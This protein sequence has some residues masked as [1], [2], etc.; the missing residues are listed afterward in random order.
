MTFLAIE[1]REARPAQQTAG[2][3]HLTRGELEMALATVNGI[4]IYYEVHGRGEPVLLIMGLGANATAWV[5]QIPELSVEYR[6]IAFDNRGSGRSG[7]PD[8]AY[9]IAQM[10]DDAALLLDE[11]SIH[12][13]HVFG[14]SMGGM[15]A[16][17]LALRHPER[18]RTLILGGTMPGGPMSVMAGPRLIQQWIAAAP[19]PLPQAIEAGLTFLYSDEFVASNRE[20]LIQRSLENAHLLPPGHALQKQIM[21]VIAFNAYGRL[22][23]IHVPTL[24]LTGTHDK[25]VPGANSRLLVER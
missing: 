10:A 11:L 7:K 14:M 6:V 13:A 15:I 22:Q 8:G 2:A 12:S 23:E 21:A 17:E 19:L 20:R 5:M 16:Q 24:V 25:I 3:R 18:V 1:C 9:S 4:D